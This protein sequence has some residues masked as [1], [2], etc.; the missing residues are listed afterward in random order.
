M[1]TLHKLKL[2]IVVYERGSFNQAAQALYLAQSAVSQH[3]QGLETA[4]GTKLFERS[5]QGVQPTAAGD[6]LYRY[7][8]QMLQILA[9]AEREIMQIEQIS[10]QQ[11]IVSAT[12]GLTVYLLPLWLQQ[13]QRSY[14]HISVSLRTALTQDVVREVLHGRDDLGFLEGELAELDQPHLGR[15]RLQEIEYFVMVH[16]Q[17]EWAG[18]DLIL[19]E[20]LA[21]QPFITR[22][23]GSRMRR[24]LEQTLSAHQLRLHAV[25]ELDSPGAIKYALLNRMGVAILPQYAVE[26]EVERGEIALLRLANIPLSRPLML[27]WDKRQ[28]FSPLQ[29]A[30]IVSLTAVAPQLQILL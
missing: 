26:R 2:F 23:P 20:E 30:F 17:H 4:L 12:P 21:R 19:P 24:W 7:A 9:E 3:I 13:F 25:A 6:T 29:R 15:M 1:I 5:P 28:P 16:G 22:Q 11:L 14:P 18:R 10:E 8:Q 27:V